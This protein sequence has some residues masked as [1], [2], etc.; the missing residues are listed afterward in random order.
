MKNNFFKMRINFGEKMSYKMKFWNWKVS[1]EMKFWNFPTSYNHHSSMFKQ[2][3]SFQ[4]SY[5]T[6]GEH[7]WQSLQFHTRDHW[8]KQL[9]HFRWLPLIRIP[10]R[11]E[12]IITSPRCTNSGSASCQ[13]PG[14]LLQ[15]LCSLHKPLPPQPISHGVSLRNSWELPALNQFYPFLLHKHL[16]LVSSR[17]TLGIPRLNRPSSAYP[18]SANHDV[19]FR[20][21]FSAFGRSLGSAQRLIIME[22]VMMSLWGISANRW[23]AFPVRPFP[24]SDL[25]I[26]ALV[27]L[28]VCNV[29]VVSGSGN[30]KW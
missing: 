6:D 21:G 1:R 7:H 23:W 27:R 29:N 9:N 26:A 5:R 25:L 19:S 17:T 2:S 4:A 12:E 15:F 30:G 14:E 22:Q 11:P 13:T 8:F 20:Q 3:D 10:R 18:S 28:F 16:S 24:P